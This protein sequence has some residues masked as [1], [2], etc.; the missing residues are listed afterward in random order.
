MRVCQSLANAS[1]VS[2]R[3]KVWHTCRKSHAKM[4][5]VAQEIFQTGVEEWIRS[6]LVPSGKN[7]PTLP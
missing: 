5:T 4:Q 1:D 2:L 7:S 6:G 3:Q